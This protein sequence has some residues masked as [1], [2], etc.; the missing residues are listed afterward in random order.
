[1]F[2][3][4]KLVFI[5]GPT[6]VGKTDLAVKVARVIGE[7]VSVDSMQVYRDLECGTAKPDKCALER[8]PHHLVSIVSPDFRFSAGDFR[9]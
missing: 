7:I 5:V 1:M 9:R 8:V 6:G 4:Q 3:K 2:E